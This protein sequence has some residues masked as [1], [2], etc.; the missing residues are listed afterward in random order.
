MAKKR[1]RE[2]LHGTCCSKQRT[3]LS[4]R[5]YI[6]SKLS[7]TSGNANTP[8]PPKK[9]MHLRGFCVNVQHLLQQDAILELPRRLP[10]RRGRE[11]TT[12]VSIKTRALND[13][14][15][16]S[17][18]KSMLALKRVLPESF[19]DSMTTLANIVL[20]DASQHPWI[21]I[22]CTYGHVNHF[23]DPH[24]KKKVGSPTWSLDPDPYL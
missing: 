20:W 14:S 15:D 21:F 11:H 24:P 6:P 18:N 10:M 8:N 22:K 9:A 7:R 13:C 2:S 23:S 3:N 5:S 17:T 19:N 4:L 12:T 1:L 16:C